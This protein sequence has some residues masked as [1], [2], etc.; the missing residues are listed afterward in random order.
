LS[1]FG[2]KVGFTRC[3]KN[4]GVIHSKPVTSI[5]PA[6]PWD[7]HATGQQAFL[8]LAGIYLETPMSSRADLCEHQARECLQAAEQ[9]DN[10]CARDV[11]LRLALDW[12]Q[13]ALAEAR[14][15]KSSKHLAR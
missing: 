15:S 12:L 3:P 1:F 10:P 6:E 4:E 7:W 8:C 9:T 14:Q 11:L 2:W 5:T 13:D